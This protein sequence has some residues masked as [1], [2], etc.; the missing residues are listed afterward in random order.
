MIDVDEDAVHITEADKAARVPAARCRGC[1]V[2]TWKVSL[3]QG[4]ERTAAR[5]PRACSVPPGRLDLKAMLSMRTLR[6]HFGNAL[7]RPMTDEEV[8]RAH[9]RVQQISA[10]R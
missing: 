4:L 8:A 9:E 2:V 6:E 1:G 5:H 3:A 10:V 7:D